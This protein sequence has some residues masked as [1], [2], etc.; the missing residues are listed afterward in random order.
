ML[1]LFLVSPELDL[2]NSNTSGLLWGIMS[3]FS[4][5]SLAVVNRTIGQQLHPITIAFWQNLFVS[6]FTLPLLT[7]STFSITGMDIFWLSIL[8]ILC[9]ALSHFLFVS[10]V[11]YINARTTG[12]IISLEPVY[13]IIVA[14]FL[15]NEEPTIKMLIGGMLIIGAAIY[16]QNKTSH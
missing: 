15:F 11:Q 14:W 4:F 2:K 13:A 9:T 6:L 7:L 10:S 8:G 16:P 3:G 5:G 1:G 12:L